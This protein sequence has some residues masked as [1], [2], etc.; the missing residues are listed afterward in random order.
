MESGG[1]EIDGEPVDSLKAAM[2]SKAGFPLEI[3]VETK[4]KVKM[5]WLKTPK[6]GLRVH[7][8]GITAGVPTVKK[9]TAVGAA[10]ENAECKVDFRVKIW[11][12][13]V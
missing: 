4:V 1:G 5:G 12:W 9:K 11:K 2:K 13:I 6:I 8:D 7:C 3:K 10:V